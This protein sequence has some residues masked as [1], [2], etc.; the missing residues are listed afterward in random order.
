MNTTAT[1]PSRYTGT[2]IALHWLLAAAILG[3]AAFGWYMSGL[4]FSPQRLKLYNWHKW[5]GV[6]ILALSALR[7]AWRL[8]HRPPAL[9][10]QVQQ[11]MPGWQVRAYHATHH[12]MYAL[13]FAVPL[14]GW[15]YSSMSG[16]PIVLFGVLPLPD[17]VAVDKEFAK[18]FKPVHAIL[19]Y[20]LL[21][22]VALHVAA[23]V[24][25]HVVDRDG[26]LLRMRPG[27]G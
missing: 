17:F 1:S 22:L 12:L 20:T 25:H 13:F 11:A 24:K 23:A 7:L 6:T 3:S 8:T 5:A 19:A 21:A 18:V 15:A 9:P 14:A 4:P 26:L 27:R 16:F 10:R 2:A